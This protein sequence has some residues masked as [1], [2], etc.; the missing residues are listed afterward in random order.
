[1]KNTQFFQWPG[2]LLTLLVSAALFSY[3]GTSKRSTVSKDYDPNVVEPSDK[4]SASITWEVMLRRLPGVM[5][6]GQGQN[7]S[8]KVRGS[9]S[10]NLTSEPLFVLNG[11]PMGHQFSSIYHAVSPIQVKSMRVLKGPD[12]TMYGSRAANGVIVIKL[13]E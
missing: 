13:K 10:I 11:T 3:C 5:V 1:M 2:I 7:L 6:S 8:V 12:A 4:E 9:Q